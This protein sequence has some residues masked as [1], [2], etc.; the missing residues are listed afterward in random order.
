MSDLLALDGPVPNTPGVRTGVFATQN[1]DGGFGE[2][3]ALPSE[4][5]TNVHHLLRGADGRRAGGADHPDF[6]RDACVALL[7]SCRRPEGGFGNAPGF[8]CDAWHSHLA[9]LTLVALGARPEREDDLVAHLLACRNRDGGY[10]N[11]P[12]SPSDTFATF[13]VIGALIALGLRPPHSEETLLWLRGL[14]TE[15]GGFRYRTDGAESFVDS[16]PGIGGLCMRGALPADT[17]ACVRWITVRQSAAGGFSRAPG[18]PSETTDEGFI[19]IQALTG[20]TCSKGN[21]TAP[22]R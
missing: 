7:R 5:F 6:D 2:Q 22:G 21:S 16:Y 14:Q 11:R 19:A 20:C 1:P 3:P 12:G 15:A 4:T 10:G 8:P 13:R 17:E 18:A 9:T